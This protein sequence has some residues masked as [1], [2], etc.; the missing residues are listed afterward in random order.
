MGRRQSLD[1]C[2]CKGTAGHPHGLST[3]ENDGWG[4]K[5]QL[6]P[7]AWMASEQSAK[8]GGQVPGSRDTVCKGPEAG[9]GLKC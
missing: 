4:V 5:E 9:V 3:Q 1:S 6:E 2:L 7:S 8:A